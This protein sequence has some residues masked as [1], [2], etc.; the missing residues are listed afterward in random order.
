VSAPPSP[1]EAL[2]SLAVVASVLLGLAF[3]VAGGSKLSAGPAW[4]DQARGLGA[5]SFVIPVVPWFEIGLGAILIVQLAPVPAGILAL[6]T[7]VVF[8]GLIARR[9]AQGQHP[10]CAC[11]GAWS[12]KPLGPGHLVR[13]GV[14]IALALVVIVAS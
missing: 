4:P 2:S 6:V 11:F 13:N 9:L 12:A 5:P 3:V 8:T 7:L 10:P 1:S 14:L